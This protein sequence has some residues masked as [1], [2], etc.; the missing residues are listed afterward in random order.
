VRCAGDKKSLDSELAKGNVTVTR[1]PSTEE[2]NLEQLSKQSD[3]TKHSKLE[4]E[5]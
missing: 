5:L 4:M 3:K 1:A 2:I